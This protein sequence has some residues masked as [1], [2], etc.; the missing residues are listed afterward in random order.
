MEFQNTIA[1]GQFYN[2]G[3]VV[4]ITT[5]Y[6]ALAFTPIVNLAKNIHIASDEGGDLITNGNFTT[7]LSGW[8]I[9]GTD[10]TH[11][12][13]W[14]SSGARFQSDTTT[15]VL[16][17]FQNILTI[18]KTYKLTC[19]I[20]YTSLET[21]RSSIGGNNQSA[22][23]EGSNTRIAIATSNASLNFLRNTSDVDAII[24]NVI[25]KE[26][27]LTN[28]FG[29][30]VEQTGSYFLDFS[31]IAEDGDGVV[32]SFAPFINGVEQLG[33]IDFY[34]QATTQEYEVG[35]N[36]IFELTEGDFISFKV[37]TASVS[38]TA[39]IIKDIKLNIFNLQQLGI[40]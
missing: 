33:S 18:G 3:G 25:V 15:P 34:Q 9:T 10:A 6:V 23:V 27:F 5:S 35:S 12:V 20:V 31:F 7:D 37:K 38:A 16:S 22:F 36:Y 13:T 40:H 4:A 32:Y 8:T 11:T 17:F 29:V 28:D 21:L 24:S 30:Y 19:D 14:T 2:A 1:Y 26:Q 39:F